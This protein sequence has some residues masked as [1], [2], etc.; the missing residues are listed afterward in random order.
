MVETLQRLPSWVLQLVWSLLTLLIAVLAGRVFAHTVGQRLVRWA[1][2]TTWKWDDLVVEAL[3][4]GMPTWSALLGLYL[5]LGLWHLPPHLLDALNRTL[6]VLTWLS[7]TALA[8]RIMGRL[9][10]LYGSHFQQALPVTSLTEYIVKISV[11]MLGLLMILHGLGIS[12]AP[13]LTALGVGGLAIALALQDTLSNLFAGF[14]LT[15]ARQVRVGDYIQLESG[16]EGYVEDIGWRATKLRMLPNN[17]VLVPNKKL[18][19]VILTNYDLPSRDMAV[20]VEV[21][22][23]YDADL[24]RVERVTVEVGRE[25]MR[26]VAGGV[27]DFEP[28]IRY[29]TLGDSRVQFTVILRAKEFVDQFLI[30]HAFIKQLLVRYRQEGIIIPFP[31]QTVYAMKEAQ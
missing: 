20:L 23:A 29:H 9:T 19:E 14:Y 8:A 21:G 5:A 22:V 1:A 4:R 27:P 17:M 2:H 30:K 26:T 28:F 16:Q 31:T 13:L 25:V 24:E 11:V 12:I 6:Y 18:G 10:V 3:R 7:V 15:V